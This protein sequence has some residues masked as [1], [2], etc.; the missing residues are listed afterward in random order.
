[1]SEFL[2]IFKSS[3]PPGYNLASCIWIILV[4]KIINKNFRM[5][6]VSFTCVVSSFPLTEIKKMNSPSELKK[7]KKK[8]KYEQCKPLPEPPPLVVYMYVY[9]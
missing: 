3:P 9:A 7:K 4:Q 6:L 2:F 8:G 5:L 1:M